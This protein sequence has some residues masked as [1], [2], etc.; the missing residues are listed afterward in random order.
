MMLLAASG[1]SMGGS[2]IIY[3]VTSL[4]SA[5]RRSQTIS[6]PPPPTSLS[7]IE[8]EAKEED[9]WIREEDHTKGQWNAANQRQAQVVSMEIEL[10]GVV[11]GVPK[12]SRNLASAEAARRRTT[13]SPVETKTKYERLRDFFR[14]KAS[15]TAATAYNF[16]RRSSSV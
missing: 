14:H 8:A 12:N 7:I 13:R 1:T 15:A 16:E 3:L 2:K 4:F 9:K 11:K 10:E 5:R 6:T